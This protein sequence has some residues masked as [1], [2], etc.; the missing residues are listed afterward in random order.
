MTNIN[1]EDIHKNITNLAK[2]V[3]RWKDVCEK[4]KKRYN[5]RAKVHQEKIKAHLMD[6]DKLKKILREIID[7]R[8]ALQTKLQE[9]LQE[10]DEEKV[11]REIEKMKVEMKQLE[12][13]LPQLYELLE[14]EKIT[15]TVVEQNLEIVYQQGEEQY[16]IEKIQERLDQV[17]NELQ[18]KNLLT[19][20]SKQRLVK[21]EIQEKE[22][23][24]DVKALQSIKR[25]SL[26]YL[27]L[28]TEL[29]KQIEATKQLSRISEDDAFGKIKELS[30]E[31]RTLK[32][33]LS[34][35]ENEKQNIEILK[36]KKNS[37][38][39][40]F[41]SL[42]NQLRINQSKRLI[43]EVNKEK[44]TQIIETKTKE[45]SELNQKRQKEAKLNREKLASLNTDEE[46][47]TE[48]RTELQIIFQG[49]KLE[50][51]KHLIYETE[52]N[53]DQLTGLDLSRFD[54]N[55]QKVLEILQKKL[56][57]SI[58]QSDELIRAFQQKIGEQQVDTR[59]SEME[60]LKLGLGLRQYKEE[61]N[62]SQGQLKQEDSRIKHIKEEIENNQQES[63]QT[64]DELENQ[65]EEFQQNESKLRKEGNEM[66]WE[67]EEQIFNENKKVKELEE[68]IRKLSIS[69]EEDQLDENDQEISKEDQE[70]IRK[71]RELDELRNFTTSFLSKILGE[72]IGF[73]SNEDLINCINRVKDLLKKKDIEISGLKREL[74]TQTKLSESVNE[75]IEE[76]NSQI[77]SGD[78]KRGWFKKGKNKNTE[79][80]KESIRK[81]DNIKK[82]N[83]TKEKK[84]PSKKPTINAP[85]I[86][87]EDLL[88]KEKYRHWF[89]EF[90][91]KEFSEENLLF[92]IEI[93][94]FKSLPNDKLIEAS[95]SIFS[96]YIQ[97]GAEKQVNIDGGILQEVKDMM[98][99]KVPNRDIFKKAQNSIIVLMN[100]DSYSR[101][102]KSPSYQSLLENNP[103]H[104]W[105]NKVE[106]N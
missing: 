13:D 59:R 20:Q 23:E 54:L 97:E 9:K 27:N 48:Q 63:D 72:A 87:F 91:K 21:L 34:K 102:L 30:I 17:E 75:K 45:I 99:W 37:L 15:K 11:E 56:S 18:E 60:I 71:K 26:L 83:V 84:T 35:F 68:N 93:E 61:V 51:P 41:S 7:E 44:M 62:I 82:K 81:K 50:K 67:L 74:E 57:Q 10:N 105:T 29:E 70:L 94:R 16:S 96:T 3:L 95:N 40:E 65:L 1:N 92:F 43:R 8:D 103:G 12:T 90:L 76:L 73:R 89:M 52:E 55:E 39:T 104:E 24:D 33:H 19:E 4:L 6:I 79:K 14:V 25:Q 42:K 58:S 85:N 49:L 100:T 80:R 86:P 88:Y 53:P 31:I 28:S 22:L 64:I 36:K 2:E 78:K 47:T 66:K 32:E 69:N 77:N 101:F 38:E 106:K 5:E 98:D 46:L